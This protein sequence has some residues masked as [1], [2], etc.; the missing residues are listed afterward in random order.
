MDN[1]SHRLWSVGWNYLHRWSLGMDKLF[2]PTLYRTY[3]YLSMLGL[4]LIYVSTGVIEEREGTQLALNTASMTLAVEAP[5][6]DWN[7]SQKFAFRT[8][9]YSEILKHVFIVPYLWYIYFQIYVFITFS[10]ATNKIFPSTNLH[11]S[12]C[13][14]TGMWSKLTLSRPVYHVQFKRNTNSIMTQ[15]LIVH[16][17]VKWSI[18]FYTRCVKS[19]NSTMQP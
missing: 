5:W 11:I 4:K 16:L 19:R 12:M 10:W 18:E 8:R 7:R 13:K 2:H 17:S 9:F 14:S 6:W 15:L 3:G 1:E